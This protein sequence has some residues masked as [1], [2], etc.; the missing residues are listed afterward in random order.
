MM[1][2]DRLAALLESYPVSAALFHQGALCGSNLFEAR[3]GRGFLHILRAGEVVITHPPRSGAP[4]H[5]R[6]DRP[7]MLFYPRALA[8]EIHDPPEDGAQFTC[9]TVHFSGGDA[10]PLARALPAFIA[11]PLDEA[12]DLDAGLGMLF[13][14]TA[15]ILCGSR[16][17]ADRLFEVVVLQLLRWILD[18]GLASA[19][20][21]AG[22]GDAR[23]ARALTAIHDE[24]QAPWTL[25]SLARVAGM[26]RSAFAVHFRGVVGTTP[27]EYLADWRLARA[28]LLLR[29]G[30]PLSIIA[31]EVGYSSHAALSRA[32]RQRRGV[33]PTEFL[34][35][36]DTA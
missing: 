10:H 36:A 30:R 15:Q 8:H 27:A 17:I 11:V 31:G 19:G 32:F 16:L 24:P 28:A 12:P 13:A 2:F 22:L 7:T 1:A 26:S 14:E 20:L 5:V 21:V 33:T 29:R 4:R 35:E 25:E 34:R 6:I 3:E 9:A 18:R 23:L